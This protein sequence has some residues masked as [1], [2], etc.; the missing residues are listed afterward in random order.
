MKLELL[1]PILTFLAGL[2]GGHWLTLRR[3]RRKE[4][5]EAADRV[6]TVLLRES[7]APSPMNASSSSFDLNLLEQLLLPWKRGS[8][9]RAVDQY[10]KAKEVYSY[11]ELGQ[12]CYSERHVKKIQSAVEL[13]C[14][15]TRRR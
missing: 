7:Q 8:Y 15:F 10:K 6:R 1:V 11:D 12:P 14:N 5:N 3:D 2:F 9:R 13:L 4:F